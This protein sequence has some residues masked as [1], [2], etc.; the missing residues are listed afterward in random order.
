MV[1]TK[2]LKAKNPAVQQVARIEIRRQETALLV[3]I[4]INCLFIIRGPCKRELDKTRQAMT[5]AKHLTRATFM[6][7]ASNSKF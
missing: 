4:A 2:L 7:S 5:G 3:L 6:P 1:F